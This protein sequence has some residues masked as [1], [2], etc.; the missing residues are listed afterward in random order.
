MSGPTPG[1][2]ATT[3]RPR[4]AAAV[5][6]AF[7]AASRA[8]PDWDLVRKRN[9]VEKLKAEK[10]P[11]AILDEAP[12]LGALDYNDVSEE[13]MVRFQ[14]YGLYHDKPKIG[15][16]MLRIKVPAG[17]LTAPQLKVIGE[18]SQKFGRDYAELTT[19]QTIQ[20]HWLRIRDLPEVF[21]ALASVGM[22]SKGGCGDAV[23]NV[24]GCPVAGLDRTELFDCSSEL[25]DLVS[26]FIN[27]DEYL[28]LPRKH[29]IS[30]AAC[31]DQCNAPEINCISFV[32]ATQPGPNGPRNGFAVHVGGGLSSTPR[33]ARDLGV[34]VEQGQA[35]EVARAILDVWRHDLKYRVSR[36]K[37]RLKF[38]VDDYGVD[39]VRKA[40]EEKLG[41]TLEDLITPPPPG[42]R[43]DH[44]GV[45]Q[46]KED[47]KVYIGVPVFA[48]QIN[49]VQAVAIAEL[50]ASYGGDIRLTRQQNFILTGVPTGRV[51]EI[52]GKLREIGFDLDVHKLRGTAVACTGQPLCNY[53][54]AET[55]PK[56]R[57]IVERLE[58]RFGNAVD[59]LSLGVDGCPHA[60]AH[61]WIS[62]IG[63]QGT[64]ARGDGIQKLEAY[65]VYLRGGIGE[66]ATVGRAVLRRVPA[67]E[68]VDTV[69]RLV[70]G[71]LAQR[72]DGESFQAFTRRTADETL[73]ALASGQEAVAGAGAG[74]AQ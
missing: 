29:K 23:R 67:A 44:L 45:H 6:P 42:A 72:Q 15:L 31:T 34:F 20:L 69:E 50:A 59:G 49:A 33:I 2:E 58:Q 11:L 46:Q 60:C 38:L 28:D 21:A 39:G 25:H 8:A 5:R 74:R 9:N 19:R 16:M 30:M 43:I 17:H 41:R 40:V 26:Y 62:D 7:P 37:A 54:V 18:L 63:L 32:G 61:H 12:A 53:A 13:D 14:W 4:P 48:G 57:E 65:E 64:T 66:D 47:G 56:M 36:A 24:T 10:H 55:K 70:A 73:V 3:P 35:I 68:A 51:D 1:E 52:V 27:H 22:T 71:W